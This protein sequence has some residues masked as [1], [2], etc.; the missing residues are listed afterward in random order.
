MHA[1]VRA[2]A[3][4]NTLRRHQSK[5]KVKPRKERVRKPNWLFWVVRYIAPSELACATL[6]AGLGGSLLPEL[7]ETSVDIE[8]VDL[9][10]DNEDDDEATLERED[11]HH[12]DNRS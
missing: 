4:R 5:S 6:G 12:N 2:T 7:G 1:L 11:I 8:V 3:G 9:T 10:L